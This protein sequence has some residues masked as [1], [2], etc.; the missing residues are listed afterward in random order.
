MDRRTTLFA[1]LISTHTVP[2]VTVGC[3][4][5]RRPS[6]VSRQIFVDDD[7]RQTAVP[8]DRRPVVQ[9]CSWR[10]PLPM[11]VSFGRRK[12]VVDA[13]AVSRPRSVSRRRVSA[14][15]STTSRRIASVGDVCEPP[16]LLADQRLDRKTT[17]LFPM[18]ISTP[19]QYSVTKFDL[20]VGRP[21]HIRSIAENDSARKQEKLQ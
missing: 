14:V 12:S 21:K 5:R 13:A 6:T 20:L 9:Q 16:R 8:A 2:E 4:T 19:R 11:D 7:R 1:R 18:H 10:V 15:T 3:M 17:E